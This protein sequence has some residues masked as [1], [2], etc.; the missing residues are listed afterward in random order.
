M[1]LLRLY[2]GTFGV[3]IVGV[4][5]GMQNHILDEPERFS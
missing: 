3:A 1:A 4:V 5:R 2:Y